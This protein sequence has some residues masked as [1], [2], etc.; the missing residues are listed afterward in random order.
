MVHLAQNR[1][2]TLCR[3]GNINHVVAPQPQI[4]KRAP[5]IN[6]GAQLHRHHLAAAPVDGALVGNLR[7]FVGTHRGQAAAGNRLKQRGTPVER[8]RPGVIHRAQHQHAVGGVFGYCNHRAQV[9]VIRRQRL[10]HLARGF[11]PGQVRHHHFTRHRQGNA[12]VGTHNQ[13][14]LQLRTAGKID[15]DLVAAP[16]SIFL[17]GSRLKLP[18]RLH[19]VGLELWIGRLLL[20]RGSRRG[21][22]G[23]GAARLSRAHARHCRQE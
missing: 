11:F 12:A 14:G 7:A 2:E 8:D 19:R 5:R 4:G 13:L 1:N 3:I 9:G 18:Q 6:K 17:V 21:S 22:G 10:F 23:R 15:G 20:L 16:Q